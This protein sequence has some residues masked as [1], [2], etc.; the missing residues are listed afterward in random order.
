M[1]HNSAE[2][3]KLSRKVYVEV[4]LSLF[5][6]SLYEIM[7]HE[8]NCVLLGCRFGLRVVGVDQGYP[9][10]KVE[11]RKLFLCLKS[12]RIFICWPRFVLIHL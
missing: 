12:N 3:N 9:C 2:R 5:L 8:S 6:H 11:F 4:E 7:F 1:F 10:A